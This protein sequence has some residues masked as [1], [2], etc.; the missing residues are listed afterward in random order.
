M[1]NYDRY[2][3]AFVGCNVDLPDGAYVLDDG[4]V[5]IQNKIYVTYVETLYARNYQP[6]DKVVLNEWVEH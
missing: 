3:T 5:I 2:E 6:I 4:V 1:M